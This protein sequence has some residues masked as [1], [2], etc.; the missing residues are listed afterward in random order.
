MNIDALV[1][2]NI[3][4][5]KPYRSARRLYQ[6]GTFFDA[7]E[8]AFGSAAEITGYRGLNRYPDP[9]SRELRDEL[10]AYLG[11]DAANVCVTNGSDEAIDLL[12]RIFVNPD[13]TVAIVEPTYGMYRVAADTAG[14]GVIPFRFQ[15]DFTLDS[16]AL[17]KNLPG[18]AKI[19]FLCSPNNP[20]GATIPLDD[21][22]KICARF[23]GIV[24]V[25]EAYIEFSSQPSLAGEVAA[26]KNLVVLR[27]FSKAWGLAGMRLGYAVASTEIAAYLD[28]VKPPYNVNRVS[29]SLALAALRDDSTMK[30]MLQSMRLEKKQLANEL[31]TLGFEIFPS[32]TNFLLVK[33]PEASRMARELAVENGLIVRDFGNTPL[34]E[35]CVRITVGT[36]KE[37]A[38]LISALQKRI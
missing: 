35:D 14:V 12:I 17:M 9:S 19:L 13:E 4:K 27:T 20:T 31:K 16:E 38:E 32:D 10:A 21:M 5:L 36:P 15:T 25:D 33:Y 30:Q 8:N 23:G 22:R 6:R 1:R 18:S 7:N 26:I 37:N 24:A 28:K 29:Q 2:P 11:V 34:L 3:R